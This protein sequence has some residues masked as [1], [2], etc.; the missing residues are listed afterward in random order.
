MIGYHPDVNPT[1]L[2]ISHLGL[3]L[4][5]EFITRI[6]ILMKLKKTQGHHIST[7][8][9]FILVYEPILLKSLI[10]GSNL[11]V[12]V[13]KFWSVHIV[14]K[15]RLL[16]ISHLR[17]DVLA[18][19]SLVAYFCISMVFYTRLNHLVRYRSISTMNWD[20]W[21]FSHKM[22]AK[23]PGSSPCWAEPLRTEWF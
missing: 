10:L 8:D 7:F 16:C 5:M 11:E 2:H 6:V 21:W 4:A 14:N 20:G 3:G 9:L 18:I 15:D 23:L 17:I 12:I 19:L 1:P 13:S 22:G